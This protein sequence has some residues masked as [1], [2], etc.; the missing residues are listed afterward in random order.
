MAAEGI[1]LA[2]VAGCGAFLFTLISVEEP[3]KDL[4]FIVSVTGDFASAA[5]VVRSSL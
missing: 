4:V 2:V 3:D 1:F 5:F